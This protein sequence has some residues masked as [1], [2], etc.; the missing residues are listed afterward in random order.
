M[1]K[2]DILKIIADDPWMMDA[3][4]YA[5]SLNLPEWMMGAGFVRNKVWDY[6]HGYVHDVVPTPDLD[7]IY[8]DRQHVSK[9]YDATLSE[10]ALRK[11]GINWE[12]INQ[13]YTHEWH[14]REPYVS[15]EQALADW[16]ETPTCVAVSMNND[17][18]LRLH[19]PLGIDDLVNLVVRKNP[20]C[21]DNASYKERVISKK[22]QEK[23]PKLKILW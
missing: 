16:V 5:R 17:D 10:A 23:W 7:L 20:A 2:E 1:T 13:A 19:A 18:S 21:L 3:L 9:E 4:R 12:I 22:W 8:L 14:G 15:T 11:T 6:L